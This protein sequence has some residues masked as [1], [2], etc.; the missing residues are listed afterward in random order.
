MKSTIVPC[1]DRTAI[2]VE[3]IPPG[4]TARVAILKNG[5][6]AAFAWIDGDRLADLRAALAPPPYEK[7]KDYE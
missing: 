1:D 7:P 3:Q 6:E 5:K 4:V 2:S